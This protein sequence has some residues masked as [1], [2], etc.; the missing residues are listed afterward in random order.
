MV[1]RLSLK[2]DLK[3]DMRTLYPVRPAPSTNG[4]DGTYKSRPRVIS[5]S[6][7]LYYRRNRKLSTCGKIAASIECASTVGCGSRV[8]FP[9]CAATVTSHLG[10]NES[11][12]QLTAIPSRRPPHPPT[13]WVEKRISASGRVFRL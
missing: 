5:T 13:G 10:E 12:L 6:L 3:S 11:G 1:T 8:I 2:K 9:H 7:Y 4:H